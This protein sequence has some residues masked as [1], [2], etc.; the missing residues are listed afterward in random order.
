MW[1]DFFYFSK[2]ER[3]A[4]LLLSVLL[5]VLIAALLLWPVKREEESWPGKQE[6]IARIENF[7][8]GIH[9][10]EEKKNL[11][12]SHD[13]SEKKKVI[14]EPFD[15]NTADSIRLSELGLPAFI[16]RNLLKYRKAGGKFRT[17]DDFSKIYG[18][19][20][21][22][23]KELKP[24]IQI[25]E[26]FWRKQD[27]LLVVKK[28]KSDTVVV[29]KYPEGMLVELN[30]ADTVE[31]K[32]IPGIG[33]AIAGK[34]VAYRDRLGGF[35]DISQLTEV[36]YVTQDMLKWF[37]IGDMPVCRINAN[38][39]GLDILRAHPYMNFY[40]AKVIIEYRRKKG[41]LKSLSQ[42]S[43]YEEFTEKDLERLSHY[44]AFD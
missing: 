7:L 35:Y 12:Y 23:Y 14:L 36:E 38:K 33:S 28:E 25:S 31:L 32:K 5:F 22:K 3:R 26:A 1:K 20:V 34:I 40:Q 42:L 4:V 8:A 37:K 18:L 6:D 44:L 10:L 17:A 2:G 43:L 19:S 13:K 39:V 24:Y 16:V 15:P 27:T 21:E 11:V 9:T 29:Y 41:K 30:A